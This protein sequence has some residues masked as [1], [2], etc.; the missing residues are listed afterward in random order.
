MYR[1]NEELASLL[2]HTAELIVSCYVGQNLYKIGT[3]LAEKSSYN[4][5]F[6]QLPNGATVLLESDDEGFNKVSVECPKDNLICVGAQ[7]SDGPF[8]LGNFS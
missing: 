2:K 7:Y 6:Y 4:Y 8:M 1:T 5:N 3:H